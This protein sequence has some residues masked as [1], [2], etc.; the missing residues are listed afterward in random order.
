MYFFALVNYLPTEYT[1]NEIEHEKRSYH[2]E[3]YKV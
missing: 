2:D 3:W 1:K